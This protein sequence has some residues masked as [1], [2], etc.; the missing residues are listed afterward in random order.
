MKHI[1]DS[2]LAELLFG[3]A[4]AD[5]QA[6]WA[7]HQSRCPACHAR[8]N[9]WRG[10]RASMDRW[11]AAPSRARVFGRSSVGAWAAAAVLMLGLGLAGGWWVRGQGNQRDISRVRQELQADWD[12]KLAQARA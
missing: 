1:S 6:R 12:L 8:F 11:P 10:A 7:E 4:G 9:A 2:E 3:E 5:L